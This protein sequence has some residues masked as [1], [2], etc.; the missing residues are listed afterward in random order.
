[1][2]GFIAGNVFLAGYPAAGVIEFVAARVYGQDLL[3]R[4]D[5]I[6]FFGLKDFVIDGP[7]LDF[8]LG[9]ADGIP[10]S[11]P[12]FGLGPFEKLFGPFGSQYH[13]PELAVDLAITVY[14]VFS[15]RLGNRIDPLL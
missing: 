12:D 8:E 15:P 14:Q 9:Q 10:G 4:F 7:F 6:L 2:F 3:F 1:M 13:K 11:G 5:L